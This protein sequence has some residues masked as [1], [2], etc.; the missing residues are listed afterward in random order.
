MSGKKTL[1]LIIDDVNRYYIE[2]EKPKFNIWAIY[3]MA[4]DEI[5][6]RSVLLFRLKKKFFLKSIFKLFWNPLKSIELNAISGNIGGGFWVSHNH[7]VVSVYSAGKNFRVG[8]GV[9]IGMN[10]DSSKSIINPIIGDNVYICANSSVIG[11]INIGDNVVV[12]AG[13]VVINDIP[14]NSTVAGNPAQIIASRA[15]LYI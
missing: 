1:N 2:R 4:L 11:G 9:V 15:E 7:S 14:P 12:C 13:S 6:F 10:K 3:K 8:P 5:A